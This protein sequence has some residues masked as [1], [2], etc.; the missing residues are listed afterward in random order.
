MESMSN[1]QLLNAWKDTNDIEFR[2]QILAEMEQ[3]S[4]RPEAW[5]EH[6]DTDYGLYPDVSDPNFSARLARKTEFYE[7]A[8]KPVPEDTCGQKG[9][10]FNTTA[11]QRL[12]ARFLH[13]ETP[14][15]GVLLFHGVGVGKT[16]TAITAAETFLDAMAS[17]KVYIIAPQA[18]ADGFRRT[19]FDVNRLVPTTKDEYALTKEV[20]KSP[21]CTGM[22]YV[23]LA[24]Q[25]QNP[26]KDEVAKE[27]EKLIKQ[28]YKIMG[29][30]AFAN[31]ILS[32]FK[33]IPDVITG[34]ARRDKQIEI[35]R[36]LFCDHVLIID[37]AHNLRDAE[38]DAGDAGL[39]DEPDRAK[40]TELAEG[41]R[42]T[43]IL[44][45]ILRVAEGL[46]LMLMTATPMY[47]T[48][49]EIVFLLN[50]LSLNDTKNDS[51][52]LDV[53]K[54]FKADGTFKEGGANALVRCIKRY[55]SYMRGENPNT[56]P[57]RLSPPEKAGMEFMNAYPQ[58]SISRREGNVKMTEDDK[59]IMAHLPLVVHDVSD[60][61]VGRGLLK[62][63]IRHHNPAGNVGADTENTDRG[64]EISD[65][66]LD[67][68][69]QMGNITYPNGLFG[70]KGWDAY[71]KESSAPFGP[72][73]VKQYTW[74]QPPDE[75]EEEPIEITDVFQGGGL[76]NWAPKIHAI[77]R[78]V[79]ES[80]GISFL[81]SRYIKA[82]ALP[83]AIALELAGWCRVLADGTPAPLLLLEGRRP[84]PTNY[85]VLL[86]SD[87]SLSPNFAGLIRYATQ[88][89]SEAQANGAKVKAI[90]GSQVASEGLD[91]KCVREIHLLD[92]WYHLNR[93]EQ[94]EGRGVRY[95]SHAELPLALR[96]CTIYL[97]A[98][99]LEEYE[100]ADLYAY[101]LAVRKAQPIGRVTRLMKI[102]AWDCM[103]N[104]DAIL[105]K[106]MG[107]REVITAQGGPPILVS[108]QDEPYTSFCDFSGSCAYQCA[109]AKKI[110]PD[111]LGTDH[112]TEQAY[113]FQRDFQKR[114]E[115]LIEF[116]QTETAMPIRHVQALFYDGIPES[117]AKIGLRD[118]I[119][120]VKLYRPDGIYG[121]LKLINDYIVF[122]PEGVTDTRIPIALR[123]GRAYGRMPSTFQTTQDTLIDVDKRTSLP[124]ITSIDDLI[125]R[126]P[127][128]APTEEP[129]RIASV[130]EHSRLESAL[131]ALAN[132]DRVL[133]LFLTQDAGPIAQPPEWPD[134]TGWRWIFHHFRSPTIVETDTKPIAYR[135]FMDNF[136]SYEDHLAVF[137]YWL[138]QGLDTLT[139]Y[140]KI[141]A[142]TFTRAGQVELFSGRLGGCAVVNNDVKKVQTYCYYERSF[143]Q[144]TT[145]F[146]AE[147]QERLGTP[148][149]RLTGT[150]A[151]FGF[152]VS[153]GKNVVFKTVDKSTG[154]MN[155]A[156]CSNTSNL[157]NHETRI[158]KIQDTLKTTDDP[159][160]PLLL[161]DR[162]ETRVADGVRKKR[163][164]DLKKQM[165][166]PDAE[167][168]IKLG[169]TSDLSLKQICPYM[170]FL[171]R[172]ADR[173]AIG[174]KRWF[175]SL[176]AAA[177]AGVKIT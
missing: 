141:C 65:F 14:Y 41:K 70:S 174:G 59:I 29:Y 84:K 34:D 116:F 121:T 91:L 21:Q 42:L 90:L 11:I 39:A 93:I 142:H 86:T 46:R 155:G 28:R 45:E 43:P 51:L 101:R 13:P 113:D 140:E 122:Q 15:N 125:D 150:D 132:W 129:A 123:Y 89:S 99:N 49:Q 61:K 22:T 73:K 163:Q 109:A 26:K 120:K 153:S 87:E 148:V 7:L 173:R 168:K 1:E 25:A 115:K 2:D 157:K 100:T 83:I 126:A 48:V 154:N 52:R 172:Y 77:V 107:S 147:V 37:E 60:L 72:V 67:Q 18:I 85:Y 58:Y 27:V 44:Q 136:W 175:L 3:R 133:N 96:N 114:Q 79:T 159:I 97:H 19:I 12:V 118:V 23:R 50:L 152:L 139:G 8:S 31:W 82:G 17:A 102:N 124:S 170:E 167:Y 110:T 117:F 57:L 78:Y 131:E 32:K 54:V 38:T 158:R 63:L 108:L 35:L 177:R 5:I 95:C 111:E 137:E 134:L 64:V 112:S 98:V 71:M 30:L 80:I 135:W 156:E 146:E 104:I 106:D 20:W 151:L 24:N 6:R 143:E 130:A 171:L 92:G 16:C 105:L 10:A 53:N 94:I 76:R 33:E 127:I 56:F 166:L 162:V 62:H 74:V 66:I 138:K 165:T 40:L 161:D 36:T 69:M 4:L 176:V 169:H 149:N 128:D 103:L 164:D 119:N 160:V 88:F 81:Y 47:N 55:V 68:T 9:E 144:C 75:A 145:L